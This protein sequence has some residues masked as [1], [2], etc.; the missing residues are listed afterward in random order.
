MNRVVNHVMFYSLYG[1][2]KVFF[3]NPSVSFLDFYQ[4]REKGTERVVTYRQVYVE[5]CEER[6]A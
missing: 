4:V 3:G 2:G 1:L 6:K 5:I